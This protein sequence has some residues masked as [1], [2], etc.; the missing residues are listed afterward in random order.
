MFKMLSTT[1]IA[2]VLA[3]AAHA[4]LVCGYAQ[5]DVG[6]PGR[7]GTGVVETDVSIDAGVWTVMHKLA[8]G[9]V[10]DRSIQYAMRNM[11]NRDR[12]QWQ[13]TLLG[14]PFF[15]MVGEIRTLNSTGQPSY[16]E[17]LYDDRRGGAL[18]M[19]SWSLCRIEEAQNTAPPPAQP[20]PPAPV[21]PAP[22]P[23]QPAPAPM[24]PPEVTRDTSAMD[25]AGKA[26]SQCLYDGASAMA[27]ISKEPADVIVGA[28]RGACSSEALGVTEA[29]KKDG[30]S[31]DDAN[32][33]LDA[34]NTKTHDRMLNNVLVARAS[35]GSESATPTV[36]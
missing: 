6:D 14:R 3:T 10:I 8:S 18:I 28:V 35:R 17:W 2:L 34:I 21:Q 24:P 19:H 33:Y 4:G 29:A 32:G 31:E 25:A 26:Y 23:V 11:S 15:H 20:A 7:P 1:A 5:V 30:Y 36:N 22:A 16:N 12:T 13:G 9:D 27:L